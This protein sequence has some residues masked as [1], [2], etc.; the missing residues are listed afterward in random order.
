[1]FKKKQQEA[2]PKKK[3]W[4]LDLEGELQQDPQEAGTEQDGKEDRW[5]QAPSTPLFIYW[6]ARILECILTRSAGIAASSVRSCEGPGAP[7]KAGRNFRR[8]AGRH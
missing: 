6:V 1:M 8:Q 2:E 7:R 5:S 4:Q 3:K